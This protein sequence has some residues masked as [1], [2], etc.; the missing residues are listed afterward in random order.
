MYYELM[1]IVPDKC[2]VPQ[3]PLKEIYDSWSL[4]RAPFP[5][6]MRAKDP[7]KKGF[8]NFQRFPPLVGLWELWDAI[9]HINLGIEIERPDRPDRTGLRLRPVFIDQCFLVGQSQGPFNVVRK[10]FGE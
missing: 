4:D 8:P 9:C 6:N 5:W 3:F 10:V 2:S 7:R 1:V